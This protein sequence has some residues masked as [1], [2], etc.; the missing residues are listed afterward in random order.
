MS[1]RTA[2]VSN[3][4]LSASQQDIREF[5][6]FSGDLAYVEMQ[7]ESDESQLAYVTFK[8][9][10]GA[11]TAVLLSGATIA[12]RVVT[13]TYAENYQ[14]PPEAVLYNLEKNKIAP[15]DSAVKRTEDI[16]SSMLAK[17]F[18]LGKDA[19]NRARSF[20]ERHHLV[21]NA[22]ATVASIDRR[23]GL[24]EKIVMGTAM[25]N[26]KMQEVD[27]RFQ[28]SE[29][30]RSA[31]AAAE[32]KASTASSNI[33]SNQYVSTGAWW[34]SNAFSRVAKAAEDVTLMTRE[35]VRKVEEE[36][37]EVLYRERREMVNEFAHFHLDDS[38]GEPAT[39]PVS[40]A[41]EGKVS[42]LKV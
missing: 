8:D 26:E 11:D 6:S 19:L 7:S 42:V 12:D 29:I 38:F 28:V 37:K 31:I 3:I 36:K 39:V 40:S 9:A 10:Q 35:K 20:D 2:K 30:T 21:S 22:T 14:L 34:V 17:G 13:V 18:V 25:V 24:S 15:E 5:F 33:M 32:Q 16:V 4:S 27:K 41:D 1:V 23:L